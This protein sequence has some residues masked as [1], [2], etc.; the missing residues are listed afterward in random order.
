MSAWKKLFLG[1][2]EK[3]DNIRVQLI[4]GEDQPEHKLM[5]AH[6]PHKKV[7]EVPSRAQPPLLESVFKKGARAS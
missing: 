4:E 2:L 3:W 6:V 5:G 7:L 1:D